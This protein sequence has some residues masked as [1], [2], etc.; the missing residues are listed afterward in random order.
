MTNMKLGI[1]ISQI[2]YKGT[3]VGRYVD[4][5]T[6]AIL[7]HEKEHHWTFFFSS[8]RRRLDSG[9]EKGILEKGFELKKFQ[10]PPTLLAFLWNRLHLV[11]LETFVG[12]LDYFITSDWTEP[13]AKTARKA[14]VVHDLVYLRYPETVEWGILKNMQNRLVRVTEES[15]IIIADS[16]STARDLTEYLNVESRRVKVVYPGVE[17]DEPTA[18]DIKNARQKFGLDGPFILTVG[19]LEPRKN[20]RRLIQAFLDLGNSDLEL[21]IVGPSGWDDLKTQAKNVKFLGYVSDRELFSLYKSSLFFIFPSLWEGFG[22]PL[23]E[24]MKLGTPAAVSENSSL[25]EIGRGAVLFFDPA[26]TDSIKNAIQ[27]MAGSD[28]L[29]RGLSRKGK[30]RAKEFSWHKAYDRIISILTAK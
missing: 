1:D 8:L 23:V 22:Y 7:A 13:P 12:K 29:R 6:K 20:I 16:E 24:A 26:N 14:T 30:E 10:L 4:G 27:K 18:A 15:S 25:K 5:L 21:A 28:S 19:K 9:I 11:N 2:V 3:G 17:V